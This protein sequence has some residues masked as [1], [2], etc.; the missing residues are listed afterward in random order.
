MNWIRTNARVASSQYN[1]T[2]VVLHSLEVSGYAYGLNRLERYDEAIRHANTAL[3]IN[4]FNTDALEQR[5]VAESALMRRRATE[6]NLK[7]NAHCARG[8]FD[9]AL[10]CYK[11]ALANTPTD[12]PGD[13]I[14]RSSFLAYQAFA[15]NQLTKYVEAI[16]KANINYLH[17]IYNTLLLLKFFI[18]FSFQCLFY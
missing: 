14:I 6:L 3:A 8:E 2:N 4:A 15:L 16:E 9:Q 18:S 5:R 11:Q 17:Y 12:L 10:E 13:G 7:G 1:K